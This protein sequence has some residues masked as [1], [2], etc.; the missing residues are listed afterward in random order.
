MV[1]RQRPADHRSAC[2]G[3]RGHSSTDRLGQDWRLH[4]LHTGNKCCQGIHTGARRVSSAATVA[5]FGLIVILSS[6]GLLYKAN[7]LFQMFGRNMALF[8]IIA[9]EP[10]IQQREVVWWLF[11]AWSA[12]EIVR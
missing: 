4:A 10:R 2:V 3:A 5:A 9:Q 8:C 12:A 11:V 6:L 1:D 7:S